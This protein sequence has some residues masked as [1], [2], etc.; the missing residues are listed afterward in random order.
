MRLEP[1]NG[2]VVTE[3]ISIIE[4]YVICFLIHFVHLSMAFQVMEK[5]NI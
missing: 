3:W 5:S 4:F 2:T 1:K